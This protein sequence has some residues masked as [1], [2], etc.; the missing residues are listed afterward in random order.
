MMQGSTICERDHESAHQCAKCLHP[1]H[2]A[3]ACPPA[4]GAPVPKLKGRARGKDKARARRSGSTDSQMMTS[5][6]ARPLGGRHQF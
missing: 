1:G 5:R 3:S 4:T 6:A 2:G